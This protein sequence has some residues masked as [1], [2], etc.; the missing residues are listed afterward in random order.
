MI[1]RL[2]MALA[3]AVAWG[4]VLV[5]PASAAQIARSKTGPLPGD[6]AP[7]ISAAAWLRGKPVAEYAPGQVYVVD[8]WATW[9]GPCLSSMPLLRKYQDR[10]AGKLTVIAMNVWEMAPQ[11]V[12]GYVTAHADSMPLF[13]AV[14]SIPPGKEANEGL[15]TVAF[16]GAGTEVSIPRT[17]LI[18]G[19]G[20]IAWIGTAAGLEV[21]LKQVL[22]GTWDLK[23]HAAAYEREMEAEMA[24]R[25][26]FAPIESSI[27]SGQWTAAFDSCDAVVASDSSY[28]PRI[29]RMGFVYLAMKIARG[30]NS[31][32]ADRA[33]A[34]RAM[35]RALELERPPDWRLDLLAAQAARAAGD[36]REAERYL[37]EARRHAPPD[38]K[39][40]VPAKLTALPATLDSL[41]R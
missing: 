2:G 5:A 30:K 15:T 22:A 38:S 8:L 24:W 41:P 6:P 14:D 9:C 10:Y 34:Q 7:P 29:A 28:A 4:V 37:G 39:M 40:L 18:D 21:P 11:R 36:T 12:P 20:R 3:L 13:V 1:R 16:M 23:A 26:R 25:A 27:E 32:Q 35:A 31:T 17:C 19:F 33:L